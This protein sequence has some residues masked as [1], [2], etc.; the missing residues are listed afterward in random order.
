MFERWLPVVGFEGLYEVSD[1]GRVRSLQRT[2]P[3]KDGR[4]RTVPEKMLKGSAWGPYLCVTLQRDGRRLRQNIQWLVM[5]AFVG[6]K[7]HP[8]WEVCHND[9]NHHN[10]REGNLRYDTRSGNF[11]DKVPHN[12]HQRGERHGQAKLTNEQARSIFVD[13]RHADI[14]ADEHRVSAATVYAI[15]ARRNWRHL[16]V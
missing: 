16:G 1:L 10:N 14:V 8:D 15:R 3:S 9:G 6:P 11:A 13:E 12:T 7:L 5:L 4:L 2:C